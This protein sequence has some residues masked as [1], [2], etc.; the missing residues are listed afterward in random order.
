[1]HAGSTCWGQFV[2]MLFCQLGGAQSLREICGGLA[3]TEGK[4]KHLGVERAPVR[5]TLAYANEH[6]P[7]QLYEAVFHQLLSRCRA[8]PGGHKFR[9][10]NKLV[11]MDSTSIDLCASLFDWARFKRTKGAVK[12]H[13]LLDH[14]GYLPSYAVITDGKK[15]DITVARTIKFAPGTVLAIDRG[16]NDYDWFGELTREGVIFVTRMKDNA[17]YGVVEE[18]KVPEKSNVLSDKVIFFYRMAVEG[19]EHF[20]RR[21][22]VWDEDKQRTLVVLTN[23]LTFGPTTIVAI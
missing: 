7:W 16:Y 15:S 17:A 19:H 8:L 3:A 22:E 10:K 20:F 12:L 13:L 14:D 18:R 21:I 9:F 4:L 23:H 11:S 1:M 6:R 2:A 5:S